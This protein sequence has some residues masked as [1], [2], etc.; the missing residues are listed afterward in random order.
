MS[1][2]ILS[3]FILSVLLLTYIFI[4]PASADPG[5]VMEW[6]L[7]E[8]SGTTAIDSS[9][10]GNDGTIYNGANY[11]DGVLGTSGSAVS[12]DGVNQYVEVNTPLSSLGNA[13][14]PY[15]LSVWVSVPNTN[16]SGN[17]VHISS[18][19]SGS[20]WC[21]PFLSIVN[22]NFTATS[23]D[24]NPE[25]V[26][27]STPA[28]PNQWYNLVTSW[29]STNGLRLF[30]DGTLVGSYAQTV[31]AASGG[32]T[33]ISLGLGNNSCSGNV[34]FLDGDVAD[35]RVYSRVLDASD[36]QNIYSFGTPPQS[37]SSS[38]NQNVGQ[39]SNNTQESDPNLVPDTGYG[40]PEN[41]ALLPV[42]LSVS[43]FALILG[44]YGLKSKRKH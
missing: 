2:K 6:L 22:G 12:L 20:G 26:A 38:G 24:G 41:K 29:D 33:Y 31:Y 1:K 25:S 43:M 28:T 17:I 35:A 36:I 40:K 27:S 39:T 42:L 5:L 37:Q 11:V 4:S 3:T 7:N 18:N 23:Y 30:I 21:I 15:A 19:V 16:E 9:G 13:N 34:G 14:Q 10:N 44:I 8:G 32:P